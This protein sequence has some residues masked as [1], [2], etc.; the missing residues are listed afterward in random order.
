M[1]CKKLITLVL[2]MVF[3][4]VA[5]SQTS[6]EQRVLFM[7]DSV[8]V[9]ESQEMRLEVMAE[10]LKNH[11]NVTVIVAGFVSEK[12]TPARR[13]TIAQ[14]RADVVC[15]ILTERYGIPSNQ[16]IP[17]GVGLSQRYD[18]PEFNEVI[19]FFKK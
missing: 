16:M 10:Y 7:P 15:R 13:E 17:I 6:L 4:V 18:Q 3:A 2:F 12:T 5:K 9:M 19:S 1:N 8:N 11:P 14:E